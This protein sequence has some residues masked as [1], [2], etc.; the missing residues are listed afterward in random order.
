MSGWSGYGRGGASARGVGWRGD[1]CELGEIVFNTR[2]TLIA[3]HLA[4]VQNEEL[5]DVLMQRFKVAYPGTVRTKQLEGNH[6]TPVF[7]NGAQLGA[8]LGQAGA[9]LGKF[10]IGDEAAVKELAAATIELIRS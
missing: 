10:N 1:A 9:Q 3:R 2:P 6:L 8:Q 7:L 4:R 5:V